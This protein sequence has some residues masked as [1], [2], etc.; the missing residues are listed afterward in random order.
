MVYMCYLRSLKSKNLCKLCD[1]ELEIWVLTQYQDTVQKHI[2]VQKSSLED[3]QKLLEGEL[4]FEIRMAVVYRSEKKKILR[5]QLMMVK[6]L[7]DVLKK[8]QEDASR[9]KEYYLQQMEQNEEEDIYLYRRLHL[10]SY[11]K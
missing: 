9:F 2:D 1:L 5:S 4:D 6:Y 8:T 11:L 7:L 3:D 10:N